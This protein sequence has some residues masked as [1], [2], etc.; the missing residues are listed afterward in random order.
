MAK[1]NDINAQWQLV[2]IY[3]NGSKLSPPIFK[4]KL[5][6]LIQ[7]AKNNELEAQNRLGELY[8]MGHTWQLKHNYK[9]SIYWY[10]KAAKQND[11]IAMIRIGTF[12][13]HGLGVKK[14]IL[15]AKKWFNKSKKL[16]NT[17]AQY[18]LLKLNQ[19]KS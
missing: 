16:G 13:T 19:K 9:K 14:N 18:F 12:Y 11:T 2:K 10:K 15:Q 7:L 1:K 5:K 4:K 3:E 8:F 6:W 17:D